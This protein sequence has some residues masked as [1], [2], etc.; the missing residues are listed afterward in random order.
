M[1]SSQ[2]V[3]VHCTS[4]FSLASLQERSLWQGDGREG[5]FQLPFFIST[6]TH[7]VIEKGELTLTEC[8]LGHMFIST[9]YLCETGNNA[10]VSMLKK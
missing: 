2:T 7:V 5:H 6:L 3:I 9:Y 10:L 4:A 8:C 1:F